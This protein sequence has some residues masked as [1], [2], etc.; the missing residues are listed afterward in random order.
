MRFSFNT[1]IGPS[2]ARSSSAIPSGARASNSA[3]CSF[4]NSFRIRFRPAAVSH[5]SPRPGVPF[6]EPEQTKPSGEASTS[7][8]KP[9]DRRT[10]FGSSAGTT[11]RSFTTE[12][13]P[14]P[15][16]RRAR[17]TTPCLVEREVR[18]VEEED[19]PD[20]GIQRVEFEGHDRRALV[21]LRDR[22]LQLDGVGLLEQR[23]QPLALF[24]GECGLASFGSF[25]V[26]QHRLL[27]LRGDEHGRAGR[28]GTRAIARP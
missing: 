7:T 24:L 25:P 28:A 22:Q 10:A 14:L 8:L 27:D 1:R 5:T 13:S 2:T 26:P 19:L 17:T 6:I 15:C 12:S 18:R 20:L 21:Q 3:R 16:D 23:E 11:G 4:E 9:G